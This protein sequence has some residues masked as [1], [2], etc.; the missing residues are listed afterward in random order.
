MKV[1]LNR[2]FNQLD[3]KSKA[4]NWVGPILLNQSQDYLGLYNV[5]YIKKLIVI[6]AL[7]QTNRHSFDKSKANHFVWFDDSLALKHYLN[8][9]I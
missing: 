4:F 9:H 3:F 5:K 6:F 2:R 7:N 1:I 8:M